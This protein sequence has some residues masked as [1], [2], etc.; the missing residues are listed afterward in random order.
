MLAEMEAGLVDLIKGSAL[1]AHL[2]QIG[3]L[4]DDDEDSLVRRLAADAPAVYVVAG[5]P[6]QIQDGDVLLIKFGFACVARNARGHQESRRGDGKTLGVYE[7][8]ESVLGIISQ[9]QVAGYQWSVTAPGDFMQS[10]KLW[11]GGLT[12]ALITIETRATMPEGVDI[13]ALA[14]FKTFD[15]QYDLLPHETPE[16]RQPWLQEPPD[17]SESAP[18]LH[19]T[20]TLQT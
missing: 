12:V 20:V 8:L 2:K 17:H 14:D 5:V 18:E 4:P 6:L 9:R 19:E 13:D 10:E 16:A 3:T 11:R 15:A 1:A 7:I